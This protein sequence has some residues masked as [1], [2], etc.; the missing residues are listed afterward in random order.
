MVVF[1]GMDVLDSTK[2]YLANN[3][4][5]STNLADQI[6]TLGSQQPSMDKQQNL[7]FAVVS[8][9]SVINSV[10]KPIQVTCTIQDCSMVDDLKA[11]GVNIASENYFND[12]F[13]ECDTNKCNKLRE[14]HKTMTQMDAS[15]AYFKDDKGTVYDFLGNIISK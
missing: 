6:A 7:Q 4:N 5:I 1:E 11:Q 3:V 9:D 8:E 15:G 2:N 10:Y 14:L 13:R 12:G